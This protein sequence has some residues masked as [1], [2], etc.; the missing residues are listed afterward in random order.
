[1]AHL[2]NNN[3]V[4]N[5]IK[6]LDMFHLC[7]LNHQFS[8]GFGDPFLFKPNFPWLNNPL[9]WFKRLNTPRFRRA[10]CCAWYPRCFPASVGCIW[11]PGTWLQRAKL[12]QKVWRIKPA[13]EYKK[14]YSWDVHV[15]GMGCSCYPLVNKHRAWKS[16]NFNGH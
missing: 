3:L 2:K 11:A 9:C 5:P 8:C 12:E 4:I 1:M 6:S 7:W 10:T 13:M 16:P 15:Y 14:H